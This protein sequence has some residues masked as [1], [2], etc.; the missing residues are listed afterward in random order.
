VY[1]TYLGLPEYAGSLGLD[2]IGA[3]EQHRT[4]MDL[5]HPEPDR[6]GGGG[7]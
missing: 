6:G 5:C 1:N 7:A 3:N 4:A 2:A